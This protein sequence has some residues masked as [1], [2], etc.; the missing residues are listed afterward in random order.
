MTPARRAEL[1]ALANRLAVQ[2]PEEHAPS[3]MEDVEAALRSF[4]SLVD[5]IDAAEARA[6]AAECEAAR[7]AEKLDLLRSRVDFAAGAA[8]ERGR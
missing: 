4:G 1:R 8:R 3:G 2:I 6:V 7:L 5:A